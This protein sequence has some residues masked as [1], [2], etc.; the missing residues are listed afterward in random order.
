MRLPHQRADGAVDHDLRGRVAMNSHLVFEPAAIDRVALAERT[1]GVDVVLGHREQADALAALRRIRQSREHQVNDVG[2]HVVLAGGDEDLV[3]GELVG[4]I[5]L[6]L[7]PGAQH[8]E[9][10]AALR[11]GQAHGAGPLAAGELGQVGLLLLFGAVRDQCFVRAVREARVHRPRLVGAVHH[12]ESALAHHERQTLTAECRVAR[13][14]RP[15]AFDVLGVR[16]LEALGR[17]HFMRRPVE[18]A[19]LLVAGDIEREDDF[20]RELAGLFDHGVD[21]VSVGVG[22]G[23]QGLELV[24][25]VKDFMQHEL[26][27]TQRRV[28]DRHGENAPGQFEEKKKE[29]EKTGRLSARA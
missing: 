21:G 2:R 17:G 13:Q 3:A 14:R 28:V 12:F 4:A 5:H 24:G 10:G 18:H 9:V 23:R 7:G 16:L 8:A 15:A 27:V 11:F 26:H 1:V 22:M 29:S 20:G 19:T 25:N 6:R